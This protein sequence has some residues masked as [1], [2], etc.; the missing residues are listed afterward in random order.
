MESNLKS[1]ENIRRREA[2]KGMKILIN[3]S[4]G[5]DQ[6]QKYSHGIL[7]QAE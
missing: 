6:L 1:T 5:V 4:N 2:K 7:F 3:I